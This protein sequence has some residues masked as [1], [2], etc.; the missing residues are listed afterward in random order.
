MSERLAPDDQGDEPRFD[1]AAW[2]ESQ[3]W[4][5]AKSVPEHPHEYV[6]HPGG[7]QPEWRSMMRLIA[8]E[9]WRDTFAG[10]GRRYRYLTVG[11][12]V[13]WT[14]RLGGRLMVNRKEGP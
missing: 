9:G 8:R 4:T 1:A 11:A 7:D 10:D 5:F 12:H 2:V 6:V 13:Y 14:T 3:R